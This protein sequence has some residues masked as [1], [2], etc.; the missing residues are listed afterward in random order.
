ME[1]ISIFTE[2]SCGALPD[3]EDGSITYQNDWS[4]GSKARYKC[5]AGYERTSGD[6]WRYCSADSRWDGSATNCSS[7]FAYMYKGSIGT[8]LTHSM[9]QMH[10]IEKVQSGIANG[11]QTLLFHL[12]SPEREPFLLRRSPT[13]FGRVSK[14]L[15]I[16]ILCLN[17]AGIIFII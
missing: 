10:C 11:F 17:V 7:M 4:C 9:L 1:L 14:I 16:Q 2:K 8:W 15:L 5:D 6:Q 3:I 12:L 13:V